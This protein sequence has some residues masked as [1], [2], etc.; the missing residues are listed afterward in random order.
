MNGEGSESRAM[1]VE[2]CG[3]FY[4]TR[5]MMGEDSADGGVRCWPKERAPEC[6]TEAVICGGC[7]SDRKDGFISSG[8]F[9]QTSKIPS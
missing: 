9:T 3:L 6:M 2:H 8:S 4:F 5:A 1:C 7:R